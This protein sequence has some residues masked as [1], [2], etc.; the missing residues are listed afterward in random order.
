MQGDQDL[1]GPHLDGVDRCR[2][3][4]GE[5]E[6]F[7]RDQGELA[8]VFPALQHPLIRVDVSFGQ[9]DALVGAPVAD[10]VDVVADAHDG[11]GPAL[12][13]EAP[14]FPLRQFRQPAHGAL[15][16]PHWTVKVAVIGRYQR[17]DMGSSILL[18]GRA[19]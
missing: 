16:A 1:S 7:A 4:G 18:R 5:L 8:A 19:R 12:D 6:W 17:R 3:D 13:V 14:S 11:D 9:G 10:G 2:F 15:V